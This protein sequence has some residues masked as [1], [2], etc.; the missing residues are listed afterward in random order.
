MLM[1]TFKIVTVVA[2]ALYAVAGFFGCELSP[3]TDEIQQPISARHA[4][5]GH[6]YRRSGSFW[7]GGF[8][9]GK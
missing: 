1:K 7:S 2:V 6:Y 4:T 8:R 3:A 5:G 9:G